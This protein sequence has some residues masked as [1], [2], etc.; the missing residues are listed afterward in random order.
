MAGLQPFLEPS[1]S[2]EPLR[3]LHA[4][5]TAV[6]VSGLVKDFGSV[7]ALDGADLAC[8]PGEV[9]GLLGPNGAGKTTLLRTLFGLVRPD[10]GS[11]A[12]L[13]RTPRN[14]SG[15]APGLAGFVDRPRFYPYL[16]GRRTLRL[17]SRLDGSDTLQ[18]RDIDDALELVGLGGAADRKVGGWSTGMLQ[19]LGLAASLLRKPRVLVLDEPTEGLDPA[20]T[21]D[22]RTVLAGLAESGVAVLV[23]SHDMAEVDQL[24]HRVTIMNAGR[25]VRTGT[26]A[27]LRSSAPAGR[28]HLS[29]GDDTQARKLAAACNGIA[30]HENAA[31]GVTVS[32]TVDAVDTLTCALGAAGVPIRS[33]QLDVPPLTALFFE[34]TG[35]AA[36]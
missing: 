13:D 16:T 9:H 31:T 34:V 36:P 7:R 21:R 33:L 25:T 23:S 12:V 30:V 2:G 32:G 5:N 20:G 11:V 14:G 17:L 27:E 6:A 26:L 29:T 35:Q 8:L 15:V 4:M 1:F 3:R 10:A 22:L 28:Y 24:C 18:D 19:R